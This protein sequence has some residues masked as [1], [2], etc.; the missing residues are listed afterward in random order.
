MRI[1]KGFI[2][3]EMAGSS[4]AVPVGEQAGRF[5]GMV[6]LNETGTFLWRELEKGVSREELIG[7]ILEE[8]EGI[9]PEEAG[10]DVDDFLAEI[11]FA[12]EED[13]TEEDTIGTRAL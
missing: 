1:K 7:A 2:L 5:R 10:K 3:R 9:A 12:L 11:A 8:Y 13:G 4:Y 6:R